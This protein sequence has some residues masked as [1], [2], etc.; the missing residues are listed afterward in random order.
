MEYF[1]GINVYFNKVLDLT[2]VD[3]YKSKIVN[4]EFFNKITIIL[5]TSK[6]FFH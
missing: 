3:L 2:K 6:V 4:V 1:N 5:N